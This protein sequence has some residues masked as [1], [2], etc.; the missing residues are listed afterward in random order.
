MAICGCCAYSLKKRHGIGVWGRVIQVKYRVIIERNRIF[1][2]LPRVEP[3]GVQPGHGGPE[4]PQLGEDGLDDVAAEL[5]AVAHKV[6]ESL[7]SYFVGQ[8]RLDLLFL[9]VTKDTETV[10]IMLNLVF[11]MEGV[12]KWE[13]WILVF[14]NLY[15]TRFFGDCATPRPLSSPA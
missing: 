7:H 15:E 6:E 8:R 1:L 11:I 4:S 14:S 5:P 10:E 13:S 9:V 12:S 2:C 3:E